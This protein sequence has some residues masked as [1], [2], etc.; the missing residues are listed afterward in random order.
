[1]IV[2]YYI[3]YSKAKLIKNN[4]ATRKKGCFYNYAAVGNY[5]DASKTNHF[6]FSKFQSGVEILNF[7]SFPLKLCKVYFR[8]HKDSNS[9]RTKQTILDYCKLS[10]LA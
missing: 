7:S 6:E 10:Y 5:S 2:P 3:Y 8:R 1:M 9:K 4:K